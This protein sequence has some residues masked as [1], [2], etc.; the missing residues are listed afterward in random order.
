MCI[1][2]NNY[3]YRLYGVYDVFDIVRS[4]GFLFICFLVYIVCGL[5]IDIVFVFFKVIY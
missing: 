5:G 4:I 3:S 2:L 1:Y